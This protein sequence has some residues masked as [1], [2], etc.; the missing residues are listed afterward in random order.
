[1]EQQKL[2]RDYSD[3]V[4]AYFEVLPMIESAFAKDYDDWCAELITVEA[5]SRDRYEVFNVEML[6]SLLGVERHLVEE[7]FIV[8]TFLSNRMHVVVGVKDISSWRVDNG[9]VVVMLNDGGH[10][11]VE[12]ESIVTSLQECNLDYNDAEWSFE[13]LVDASEERY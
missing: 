4:G 7:F 10:V 11:K 8:E 9:G 5:Y 6:S 12:P 2:T 3:A 1:M 13:A